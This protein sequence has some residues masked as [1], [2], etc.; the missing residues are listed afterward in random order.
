MI[1][2]PLCLPGCR[3]KESSK[4]P[5]A[6]PKLKAVKAEA[7][8]PV[9]TPELPQSVQILSSQ[10][11]EGKTPDEVRSLIIKSFGEPVRDIGSGLRI[12]Q[13]DFDEGVL[14]FHPLSGPT[15]AFESGCFVRLIHTH[16]PIRENIIG[17]YEMY[18]KPDK[19]NNEYWIGNLDLKDNGTFTFKDSGTKFDGR[20]KQ[21]NN[22]FM[23]HPSGTFE[24]AYL[25]G[26]GP[27]TLLEAVARG[28]IVKL[29]FQSRDGSSRKEYSIA[30]D[31]IIMRLFF[32]SEEEMEF[33]M[34]RGWNNY[35]K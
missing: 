21:K 14:T 22:F 18:A 13:W 20:D 1:C 4:K 35:W 25:S 5:P 29:K 15:F 24:I 7:Q 34:N 8:Q 33:K 2:L 27:E 31:P 17:A 16:N 26:S 9:K 10:I 28:N 6:S 32:V 23:V 11:Q 30:S 19:Y 3:K 12:E